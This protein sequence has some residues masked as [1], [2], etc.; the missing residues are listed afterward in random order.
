MDLCVIRA[1]LERTAH[2]IWK[3]KTVPRRVPPVMHVLKEHIRQQQ[4]LST[5]L[6]ATNVRPEKRTQT[7]ALF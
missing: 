6:I 4:V 5:P 1:V 3:H 7:M 2:Q